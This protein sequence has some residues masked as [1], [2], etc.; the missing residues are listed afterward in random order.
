MAWKLWWMQEFWDRKYFIRVCVHEIYLLMSRGEGK[1]VPMPKNCAV[2]TNC[3]MEV[4]HYTFL[5]VIVDG[6]KW[7]AIHSSYLCTHSHYS[8]YVDAWVDSR[9]IMDMVVNQSFHSIAS[10]SIDWCV[11][12]FPWGLVLQK[13]GVSHFRTLWIL[14]ISV[15]QF[16]R[17]VF[18]MAILYHIETTIVSTC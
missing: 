1:V 17:D 4:K 16:P 3:G 6:D 2:E 8:H 14:C 7:S 11:H 5:V 15:R 12:S 10:C 9:V 13:L 18:W